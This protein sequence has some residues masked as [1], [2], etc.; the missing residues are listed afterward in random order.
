[1]TD[2]DYIVGFRNNN[3][4]IISSFYKKNRSRF[5]SYFKK[6]YQKSEDYL[7]DLY[8]ESCIILWQNVRDE[9]LREDNLT[10][11]L[12]TYLISVGRYSMMAKDRKYK[13]ILDDAVISKLRF[14]ESDEEELKNRIEREEYIDQLVK[15]MVPPC[16]E[17]LKAFYWD[18]LSGQQIAIKLGYSS[19]DSVK[20]QK[21]K[22]MGKLKALVTSSLKD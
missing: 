3:E 4:S 20:T 22:C 8:Q 9:K 10:S 14:V 11:S 13:E 16:S 18:K 1:M 5:I 2:L 15:K 12:E 19:P 17:L 7:T 6:H 21:H